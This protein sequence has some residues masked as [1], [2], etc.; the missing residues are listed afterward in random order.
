MLLFKTN[1]TILSLSSNYSLKTITSRNMSIPTKI[2]KPTAYIGT[3]DGTFHCDDVTACFM[4]KKLDRFKNHDIVRTRNPELLSQAE[5]IVDVGAV[6][7]AEKLRLDHHQRS[8]TETMRDF[9]PTIK[10]T[11]SYKP[12]RLSSSG[13]VYAI[14]GKDFIAKL[15]L[16][17]STYDNLKEEDKKMV[18]AVFDK[19]YI[20]F[21]E[22]IDAIDNGVEVAVGDNIVY[23]YH[24]SSGISNRVAR[25]NPLNKDSSPEERLALF[26][27]AMELVEN[28]IV[29][30]IQ[31]LGKLW[32]PQ[33]QRYSELLL[34]REQFDPSGQV[35]KLELDDL[36]GWRSHILDLEKELSIEGTLKYIV[37]CDDSEASPWRVLCVPVGLKSFVNRLSLKEEW[38]GKRDEELQKVS[39]VPDAVFVHMNGFT[40]GAK[41][42]DGVMSLIRKSLDLE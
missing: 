39:G 26:K 32:W 29:E 16:L 1:R 35:L 13:L 18:D 36:L 7:D 38:R 15:L 11:N 17:D 2:S 23:N 37:Y 30:G 22:E 3:H 27:R 6:F 19:A 4:L 8:F 21:F 14:F 12:V 20:E 24:I 28:E 40:G 9:H 5:I 10:T 31:F 41:T 33:R 34:K 42:L 25:L